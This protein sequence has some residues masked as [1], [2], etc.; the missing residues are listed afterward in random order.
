MVGDFPRQFN[1]IDPTPV[2][3]Y[4]PR[5]YFFYLLLFYVMLTDNVGANDHKAGPNNY[6]GK[7]KKKA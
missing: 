3:L 1:C 7:D 4:W 6:K 2:Q 5:V